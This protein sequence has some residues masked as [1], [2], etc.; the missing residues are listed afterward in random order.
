MTLRHW[1]T[2]LSLVAVAAAPALAQDRN[3]QR[4]ESQQSQQAEQ[5][6]RAE[7]QPRQQAQPRREQ[8]Q[9][10]REQAQPRREQVQPRV[11]QP[12][13]RREQA[14]QRQQVERAIPAPQAP[15]VWRGD[16]QRRNEQQV[17]RGDVQRRND[18]RVWQ[19]DVQRRNEQVRRDV[20]V[21]REIPN[22]RAYAGRYDV[23][24]WDG[25][26][27]GEPLRYGYGYSP[28]IVRPAIIQVAP[29]RPYI[30]R[31]S[32]GIGIYYGYDDYYPYGYTPEGYFDPLPGH[33][34]GG[35]RITGA[36]R[37]ARVFAD[38]YFVGIVDDFD[39]IFQHMNLEAG[40]HHI[41]IQWGASQP[42]AFDV[43]VR[44]GQTIT[45]RADPSMFQPY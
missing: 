39:G 4:R 8:A 16:V 21:P 36:P 7:P 14:P 18:P 45:F 3:H 19:G 6:R 35:V 17:W 31:P 44:P 25:G 9:P 42:V 26:R 32:W 20:A 30:Y 38:G 12:Q 28:R 33:Y 10:Q 23:R 27:Y 13:P 5:P 24:R 37:D 43:N 22:N 41:E 1:I 2:S 40:P 11:E 15:Q 34:Y 29:Y